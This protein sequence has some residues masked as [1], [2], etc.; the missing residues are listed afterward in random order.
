MGIVERKERQ[1][2]SLR[3]EILDTSREILLSDGYERLSMREVARRIEYSATTIYL[4]FKNKDEILY[5]LSE[6]AL[7]KLLAVVSMA[8]EKEATAVQRVRAAFSA[9]MD[10]GFNEPDRYKLIFM[11]DIEQFVSVKRLLSPNTAGTRLHDL[12]CRLLEE[13][14][15]WSSLSLDTETSFQMIWAFCHGLV[16]LLISRS[17]YPWGDREGLINSSLDFIC[18]QFLAGSGG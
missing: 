13:A 1:K 12:F 5:H 16:S 2:E 14:L 3:Q 10:F 8:C 7:E 4:Y 17:R 15:P 6:E 9:Y 11:T 18:G